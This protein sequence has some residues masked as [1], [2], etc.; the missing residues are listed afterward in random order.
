MVYSDPMVDPISTKYLT[1]KVVEKSCC[2]RLCNLLGVLKSYGGDISMNIESLVTIFGEV[3]ALKVLYKIGY[4]N[5]VTS[6]M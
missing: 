6:K 4:I 3:I 2:L 5:V 1:L